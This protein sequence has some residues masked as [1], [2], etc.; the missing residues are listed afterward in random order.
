VY[1]DGPA[2]LRL[3]RLAQLEEMM[4]IPKDVTPHPVMNPLNIREWDEMDDVQRKKSIRAMETYAAM[5]EHIDEAV[6]RVMR[7]L[8]DMGVADDT[9]NLI[10]HLLWNPIL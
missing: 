2:A 8:E 3:K 10:G 4:L 6:G 1:D 5:V 7:G 9:V